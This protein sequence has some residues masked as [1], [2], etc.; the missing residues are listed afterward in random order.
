MAAPNG[1]IGSAR[2]ASSLAETGPAGVARLD[3]MRRVAARDP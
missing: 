1:P 3:V 2:T